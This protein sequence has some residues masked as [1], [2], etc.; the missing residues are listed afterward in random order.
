MISRTP[1]TFPTEPEAGGSASA[2]GSAGTSRERLLCMLRAAGAG[3]ELREAEAVR[4]PED[5]REAEE[6]RAVEADPET[7]ETAC[8]LHRSSPSAEKTYL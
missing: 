3:A 5:G 6:P 1:S 4:E 2:G 8:R 7:R